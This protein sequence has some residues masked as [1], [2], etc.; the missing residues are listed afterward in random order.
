M[1]RIDSLNVDD[2][3]RFIIFDDIYFRAPLV[4][5]IL[6]YHEEIEVSLLYSMLIYSYFY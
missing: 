2:N 6:K 3:I 4:P 5:E 1:S